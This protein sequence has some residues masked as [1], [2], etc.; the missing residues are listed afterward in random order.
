M[1][2]L[3]AIVT[4]LA[5]GAKSVIFQAV[6]DFYEARWGGGRRRALDPAEEP[7]L[8]LAAGD[9]TEEG[10]DPGETSVDEPGG[11]ARQGPSH[12]AANQVPHYTFEKCTKI[13]TGEG[14]IQINGASTVEVHPR[15]HRA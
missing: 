12:Q 5:A 15:R 7:S 4:G 3:T 6:R 8:E 11:S 9:E 14:S 1:L 2:V 13:Q 10:D